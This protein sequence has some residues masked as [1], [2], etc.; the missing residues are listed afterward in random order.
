M[1]HEL[2]RAKRAG[3]YYTSVDY[4]IYLE[5]GT[6]RMLARPFMTPAAERVRQ[7]FIRR[8]RNLED[9]LR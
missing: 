8:M 2:D 4:S 6:S 7:R 1:Q 3:Y 9:K 5:Y